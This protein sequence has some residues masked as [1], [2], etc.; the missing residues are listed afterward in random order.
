MVARIT[1]DNL[2][3]WRKVL[4][5]GDPLDAAIARRLMDEVEQLQA[6]FASARVT[7]AT[8]AGA[9]EKRLA[10]VAAYNLGGCRTCR[11][12]EARAFLAKLRN[13]AEGRAS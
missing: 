7:F 6:E 8:K 1:P 2:A 4:Y 12:A 11:D 3:A 13:I 5:A 10:D 9:L